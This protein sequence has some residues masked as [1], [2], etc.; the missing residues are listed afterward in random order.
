M[1]FYLLAKKEESKLFFRQLY[2]HASNHDIYSSVVVDCISFLRFSIL[3]PL[4]CR[5]LF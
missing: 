5:T 4:S 3:F 2:F 1:S